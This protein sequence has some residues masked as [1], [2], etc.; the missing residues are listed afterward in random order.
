MSDFLKANVGY[1][2]ERASEI[3]TL[4]YNKQKAFLA[5]EIYGTVLIDGKPISDAEVD[6]RLGIDKVTAPEGKSKPTVD[7]GSYRV[8]Q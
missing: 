4:S 1:D 2:K 6:R 3:Y 8:K 5:Q 7:G